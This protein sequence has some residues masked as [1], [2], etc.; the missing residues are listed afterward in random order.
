MDTHSWTQIKAVRLKEKTLTPFYIRLKL[1][2]IMP[3]QT[4]LLHD[5]Y[6]GVYE[7]KYTCNSTYFGENKK[8]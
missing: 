4:K 1:K 2:N 5:S 7:W 3:K 8:K 6:Q